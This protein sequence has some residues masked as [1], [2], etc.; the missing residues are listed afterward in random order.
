MPDTLRQRDTTRALPILL[1]I[2]DWYALAL[3]AL[4]MARCW[5]YCGAL[6]FTR[7]GASVRCCFLIMRAQMPIIDGEEAA[8]LMAARTRARQGALL[9]E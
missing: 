1:L 9:R 8:I 5:R 7:D 6:L 3:P 2:I 4:L